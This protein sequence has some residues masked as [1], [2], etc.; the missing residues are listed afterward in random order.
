[1]TVRPI[2][3][4]V[5]VIAAGCGGDGRLPTHPVRGTVT[6]DGKPLPRAEVW[7]V[8]KDEAALKAEIMIRPAGVT[9]AD[10]A[11]TTTTY[12]TGDGAPAGEYAAIVHWTPARGATDNADE[13]ADAPAKGPRRPAFPSKYRSPTTSGLTATVA[14][15]PN[16]IA[17][18]LKAK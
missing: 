9:D 5:A 2:F 10:G 14:P 13:P 15:G 4:G 16:Q 11:F 12:L 6:F 3:V 18:D 7:L 1:M 8:P 17:L